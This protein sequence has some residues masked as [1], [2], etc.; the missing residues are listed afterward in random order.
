MDP[1]FSETRRINSTMPH[2]DTFLVEIAVFRDFVLLQDVIFG[3]P[4]DGYE[5]PSEGQKQTASRRHVVS[6]RKAVW[7]GRNNV[8]HLSRAHV[9]AL[10]D[11]QDAI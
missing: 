10:G 1:P 8:L 4:N 3:S 6:F 2:D 7:L 5:Q 9:H 11:D